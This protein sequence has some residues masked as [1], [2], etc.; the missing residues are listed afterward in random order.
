MFVDNGIDFYMGNL[1]ERYARPELLPIFGVEFADS[2]AGLP[3]GSWQGPIRSGRGW[4]L[5]RIDDRVA[6]R[7]LWR[8]EVEGR[9]AID[10]RDEQAAVLRRSKL[11]SLREKTIVIVCCSR[12]PAMTNRRSLVLFVFLLTESLF[13][14]VAGAH[15]LGIARLAIDWNESGD[16][17]LHAR[18]PAENE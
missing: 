3:E 6:S 1:I 7:S 16:L 11:D 12:G 5:V 18:I 4:H 15:E 8:D 9:L 13:N 2:L 17:V 10:W 14:S